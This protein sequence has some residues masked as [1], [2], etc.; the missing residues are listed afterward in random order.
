MNDFNTYGG[1]FRFFKPAPMFL[2]KKVSIFVSIFIQINRTAY[3][4]ALALCGEMEL[5]FLFRTVASANPLGA[6]GFCIQLGNSQQPI[7][8][9]IFFLFPFFVSIQAEFHSAIV[10]SHNQCNRLSNFLFLFPPL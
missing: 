4:T 1:V 7:H 9:K 8:F 10:H 3:N 6:I 5:T 2:K